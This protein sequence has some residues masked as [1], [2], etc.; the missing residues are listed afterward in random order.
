M[1]SSK[2]KSI[3]NFSYNFENK[4]VPD[5]FKDKETLSGIVK[6]LDEVIVYFS[7]LL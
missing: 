4:L 1:T 6:I 3:M 2:Y 7:S 5:I